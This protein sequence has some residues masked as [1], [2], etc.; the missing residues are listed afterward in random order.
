MQTSNYTGRM[1]YPKRGGESNLD[2]RVMSLRAQRWKQIIVACNT[3][4]MK[5]VDWMRLHGV[6]EK[7][8][9][10]WQTLLRRETLDEAEG[11][12]TIPEGQAESLQQRIQGQEMIPGFVDV[13]ALVTWK[14]G[15]PKPF[16]SGNQSEQLTAELVIQAGRYNL[17]IGSGI[18]ES[19]LATV[20]KVIGNA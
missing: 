16:Q 5:K 12:T 2:S 19:T 20:L 11:S 3:S 7:S 9:Y 1:T 14:E 8:F 4:G 17:Y 6:S 10:R 18:T 13:T 15:L